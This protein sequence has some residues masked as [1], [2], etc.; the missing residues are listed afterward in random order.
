[1]TETA[2]DCRTR[3]GVAVG[4]VDAIIAIARSLVRDHDLDAPAVREALCDLG[5]DEDVARLLSLGG[6][7]PTRTLT[8]RPYPA[9]PCRP[10]TS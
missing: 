4:L 10:P 9:G 5:G 6:A 1:M 8:D 7:H 3:E 2:T